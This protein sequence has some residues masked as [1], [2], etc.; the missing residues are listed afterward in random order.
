[1][2]SKA[3]GLRGSPPAAVATA[4][5]KFALRQALAQAGLRS[6]W[7]ARFPIDADPDRIAARVRYP[8]VIKPLHLAGNRGVIRVNDRDAFPA[9]FRRV[10]AII[11]AARMPTEGRAWKEQVLVEGYI[12]GE[13][14]ALEGLLNSGRLKVLAIFDKPDPLVGPYFEETIYVTPSRHRKPVQQA[15][16]EAARQAV[17][18]LGL[19]EG[20]AHIEM[21]INEEG[22]WVIEAAPRS[23]GGLCGRALRF[24]GGITLEELLLRHALGRPEAA[25]LNREQD[26][27]GVMMIPIPEAGILH[28]VDGESEAASTPDIEDVVITIG[29]GQRLVPPP[30]GA[31]YL[32]FIFSRAGTPARVEAAL[33][34]AHERFH[35][36]IDPTG[37]VN[38]S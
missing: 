6:P 30:E 28:E 33:R 10:V 4:R 11:E 13:E 24:E 22:I 27:A 26:S 8:C 34:Q 35:F 1:M 15:V 7:F 12:P 29:P 14:V 38:L 9:T 37:E 32:G 31:R 20:P 21:R 3:L 17:G 25:T 36:E 19:R 23:I 16:I 5:N 2:A 18:A